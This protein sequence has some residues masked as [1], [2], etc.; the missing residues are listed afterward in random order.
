MST[1]RK[2]PPSVAQP[3]SYLSTAENI[4]TPEQKRQY[5]DIQLRHKLLGERLQRIIDALA[6]IAID[7][8]MGFWTS[9]DEAAWFA[10]QET[11]LRRMD[12]VL[13][14]E[15][16]LLREARILPPKDKP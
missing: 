2:L 5:E 15:E 13:Q 12:E 10:D 1:I 16:T 9:R 8:E 7:R 14:E 6:D 3:V 4:V 11:T